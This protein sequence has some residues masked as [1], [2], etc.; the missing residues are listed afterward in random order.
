MAE[1]NL[2]AVLEDWTLFEISAPSSLEPT[3]VVRTLWRQLDSSSSLSLAPRSGRCHRQ[4]TLSCPRM[5]CLT[6]FAS[7]QE[8]CIARGQGLALS[9]LLS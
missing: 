7:L 6:R 5:P 2:L 4:E 3:V 8:R 1:R 9:W